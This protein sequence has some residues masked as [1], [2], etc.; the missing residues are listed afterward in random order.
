MLIPAMAMHLNKTFGTSLEG[1]RIIPQE[2]MKE[3]KQF[4]ATLFEVAVVAAEMKRWDDD[5][6]SMDR[7]LSEANQRQKK[8][9]D[10]KLPAALKRADKK[11]IFQVASNLNAMFDHIESAHGKTIVQEP[12][13]PGFGWI[14]NSLGDYACGTT[15]IEVKCSGK[16]FS[17]ADY[18]QVTIYWLLSYIQSLEKQET[19]WD[20][21]ILLNPRLNFVVEMTSKELVGLISG[22]RSRMEVVQA[23]AAFFASDWS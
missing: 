11:I 21:I 20:R 14:A 3:S 16:R 17:S 12:A 13:I 1:C 18:R 5:R 2:L 7:C 10:A 23:F 19:A 15:L 6:F 8:Y 9:Y 22:E 4:R